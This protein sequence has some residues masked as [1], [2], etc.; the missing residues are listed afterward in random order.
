MLSNWA[1]NFKLLKPYVGY[2]AYT[3]LYHK[4]CFSHLFF[5]KICIKNLVHYKKSNN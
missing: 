5:S 4:T 3:V 2:H 1:T